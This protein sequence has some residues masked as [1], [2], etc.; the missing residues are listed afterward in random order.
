M[1]GCNTMYKDLSNYDIAMD[2]YQKIMAA[3]TTVKNG[4]IYYDHKQK[5]I[6]ISQIVEYLFFNKLNDK[7]EILD[8]PRKR[9]I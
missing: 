4:Q 3:K 5:H 8:A 6:D 2:I 1:K 9:F 7:T